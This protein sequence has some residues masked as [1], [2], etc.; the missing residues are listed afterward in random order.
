MVRLRV[1]IRFSKTDDLRWIGHRD[2]MRCFERIFRRAALPLGRSEGFHPKPRMTFPLPLAVGI[3][4]ADEVMEFELAENLSADEIAKR[5]APQL[6]GGL[7]LHA[8]E[9]LPEGAKKAQVRGAA[10]EA[11]IPVPMQTGL[12]ERIDRLLAQPA[13]PIA[14][15]HGRSTVDIRPLLETLAFSGG[16]LRMRLKIDQAGSAGP[17]EVLRALEL[18][19]LESQGVALART[20][21]EIAP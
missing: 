7:R 17:R 14:R 10:Y 2:L 15:S 9:T 20:A 8:V 6:P 11:P 16:V 12:A 1:R 21:V 4:G 19:D 13:C 18:G 5:L 3:A